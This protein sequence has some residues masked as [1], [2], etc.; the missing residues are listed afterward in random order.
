[1]S[2]RPHESLLNDCEISGAY[3]RKAPKDAD[4]WVSDKK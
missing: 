4:N 1:M 3:N 2:P